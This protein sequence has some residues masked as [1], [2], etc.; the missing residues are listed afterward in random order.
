MKPEHEMMI[1]RCVVVMWKCRAHEKEREVE[2][3][4]NSFAIYIYMYLYTY[5][6]NCCYT[7]NSFML[8]PFPE[9]FIT[10]QHIGTSIS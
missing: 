3:N 4:V 8:M 5:I 10:K 2:L 1:C 7:L 9:S 6:S